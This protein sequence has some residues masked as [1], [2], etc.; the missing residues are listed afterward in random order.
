MSLNPMNKQ[1]ET[2][3]FGLKQQHECDA[4]LIGLIA[5]Y[6]LGYMDENITRYS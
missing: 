6:T 2:Y 1:I 5:H 4:Q 3:P